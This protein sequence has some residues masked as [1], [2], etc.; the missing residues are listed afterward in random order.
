MYKVTVWTT[1]NLSGAS[2]VQMTVKRKSLIRYSHSSQFSMPKQSET[3]EY[4]ET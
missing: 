1:L 2:T 3:V 4:H